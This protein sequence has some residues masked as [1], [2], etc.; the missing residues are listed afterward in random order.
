MN[1]GHLF[2]AAFESMANGYFTCALCLSRKQEWFG[3]VFSRGLMQKVETLCEIA[4]KKLKLD[5][6]ICPSS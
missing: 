2:R 6:R 3:M 4:S 5:P 1:I